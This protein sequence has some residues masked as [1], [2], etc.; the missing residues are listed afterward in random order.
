MSGVDY[1]RLRSLNARRLIRSL[2]RD[3]FVQERQRGSHRNQEEVP[4]VKLTYDEDADAVMM[5]L[6]DA[7]VEETR[8]ISIGV[9]ADYDVQ[10]RLIA[11]EILDACK[12]YD[13]AEGELDA[14][15]PF[16][17]LAAAGEMYGISPTT[18]RHQIARGV[19]KGV[20][21]GRNWVVHHRDLHAYMTQRSRKATVERVQGPPRD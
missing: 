6:A 5:L 18:L 15:N 10:G 8:E 17:S 3:G 11:L 16:L 20:K 2:V 4:A 21:A 14:P 9:Y 7:E 1:S 13:L 12:N 19:L